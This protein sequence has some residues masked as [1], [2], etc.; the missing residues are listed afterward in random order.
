MP[1][2]L[3]WSFRKIEQLKGRFHRLQRLTDQFFTNWEVVGDHDFSRALLCRRL[4]RPAGRVHFSTPMSDPT[5]FSW[6]ILD[7]AAG[8]DGARAG[9]IA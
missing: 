6:M 9:V 3:R 4:G 7:A 1:S 5:L 2:D 8:P